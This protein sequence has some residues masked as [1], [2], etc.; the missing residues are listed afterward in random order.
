MVLLW[1]LWR[2]ADKLVWAGVRCVNFLF[3]AFTP[4][5][6]AL[7]LDFVVLSLF[8]IF[9]I[10]IHTSPFGRCTCREKFGGRVKVM[11]SGGAMLPPHIERF[12]ALTGLNVS[13][14][15]LAGVPLIA[16]LKKMYF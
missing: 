6:G 9:L 3:F 5:A 13:H 2:V 15:A 8:S 4:H 12:F 7:S 11:V 1:P 16:L 10:N 14:V